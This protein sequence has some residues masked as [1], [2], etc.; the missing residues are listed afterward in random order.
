MCGVLFLFEKAALSEVYREKHFLL[1]TPFPAVVMVHRCHAQLHDFG[2]YRLP[3]DFQPVVDVM[4]GAVPRLAPIESRAVIERRVGHVV[5]HQ[6]LAGVQR[7][8][9][10]EIP[11][12]HFQ[13]DLYAAG[14][15]VVADVFAVVLE[16]LEPPGLQ[17][18]FLHTRFSAQ[19]DPYVRMQQYVVHYAVVEVGARMV[20]HRQVVTGIEKPV[21][22]AACREK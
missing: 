11:F 12:L 7:V 18:Q 21:A 17:R 8:E 20:V 1:P 10:P 4:P 13:L 14:R 3:V 16:R 5:G 15:D 19:V 6:I 9:D 22:D 2:M